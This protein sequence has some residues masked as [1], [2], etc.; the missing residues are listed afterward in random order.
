MNK[1]IDSLFCI[2]GSLILIWIG[3]RTCTNIAYSLVGDLDWLSFIILNLMRI[4]SFLGILLLIYFALR[5]IKANYH[6]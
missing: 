3:G 2:L 6:S 4:I 1:Q 5:I